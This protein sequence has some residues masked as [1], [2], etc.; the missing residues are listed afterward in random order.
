MGSVPV[1]DAIQRSERSRPLGLALAGWWRA[2]SPNSSIHQLNALFK[3][4]EN[5][6]ITEVEVTDP[7]HPLYGRHFPLISLSASPHG[8]GHV[9]VG[10]REAMT[11]CIPLAA[12]TL[13]ANRPAV[14][15][16][17]TS[18]ALQNLL[19]VAGECEALCPLIQRQS[20]SDCP[21]TCN[22]PSATTSRRSCRR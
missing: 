1:G 18:E 12:T 2:I 15:T 21:Q 3:N 22:A 7:R 17:L 11:L 14:P 4:P 13:A 5:T 6:G 16:K 19:T 8:P 20:G 10:Y 9:L